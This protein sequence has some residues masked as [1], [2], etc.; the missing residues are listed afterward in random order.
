MGKITSI[1]YL[2]NHFDEYGIDYGLLYPII[3]KAK[4]MH[5]QEIIESHREG[6]LSD[7]N[8]EKYYKKTFK[9]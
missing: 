6:F 3:K 2:V 7:E 1:D 8:S 4:Q 9:K 5:E